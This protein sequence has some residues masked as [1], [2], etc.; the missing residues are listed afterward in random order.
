MLFICLLRL[1]V[2]FSDPLNSGIAWQIM[3]L[4]ILLLIVVFF[5]IVGVLL[6]VFFIC[7]LFYPHLNNILY[8]VIILLTD[9]EL[10]A[11]TLT[12]TLGGR[13][14]DSK[15]VLRFILYFEN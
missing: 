6:V 13:T 15:Y 10:P 3:H 8:A 2:I 9:R 14:D 7:L 12:K 11:I 5:L 1:A 4:V